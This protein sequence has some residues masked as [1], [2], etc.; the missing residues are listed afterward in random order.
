[1][2][3]DIIGDVHGCHDKLKALL[4]KLGYEFGEHPDGRR[5]VFVGDIVDRGPNSRACMAHVQGL[6]R[7]GLAHMVQGNHD[8]KFARWLKGNPVTVGHGLEST[9]EEYED[10]PEKQRLALSNWILDRPTR[11]ELGDD[12]LVVHGAPGKKSHNL[13][14][15]TT[16]NKT[17]EGLPERLDWAKD[18]KGPR[19]CVYGH[20]IYDEPYIN[21][22]AAG[23]DTGCY[24]TGVLTAFRWPEREIVQT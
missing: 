17:P 21:E 11:L 4:D 19:F 2:K 5:L 6:V 24:K 22:F 13:Y 10:M 3:Y 18:Y 8:N 20:V 14:G 7:A 9:V 12:L 23:I 15:K 16:G 1:M